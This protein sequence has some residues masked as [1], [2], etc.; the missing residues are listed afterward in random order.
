VCGLCLKLELSGGKVG[1]VGEEFT[2][3][4][5]TRASI[6]DA[7]TCKDGTRSV[8]VACIVTAVRLMVT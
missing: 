6:V 1:K 8:T 7:E 5:I 3:V 2:D 4:T